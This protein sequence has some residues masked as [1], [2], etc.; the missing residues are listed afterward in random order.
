MGLLPGSGDLGAPER[1]FA[2]G[3]GTAD[4]LPSSV[5]ARCLVT[6]LVRAGKPELTTY[7][8]GVSWTSSRGLRVTGAL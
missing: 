3:P 6:S 8:P 4:R 7:E 2:L 1:S 5:E